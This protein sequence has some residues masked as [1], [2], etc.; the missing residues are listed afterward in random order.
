M[1]SA[2]L[3]AL[4]NAR[5]QSEAVV[6][7]TDLE[8]GEQDLL[9]P[10]PARGAA[11]EEA[12]DPAIAEAARQAVLTDRSRVFETDSGRVFLHVFN[13]SVHVI[14][15]GAVHIAQPL[16]AMA[17]RAGYRVTVV[18]PRAAFATAE[19]FP[20]IPLLHAWP[21]EGLS[22]LGFDRRTALVTVT[23][24]PKLD[25]PALRAALASPAF[26]VGALGSRRNHAVRLE[27]LRAAGFGD[28]DF[29][30]IHAPI[31]LDI[32]AR[33]PGE[34]A[35]AILAEIVRELRAESG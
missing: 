10:F 28:D 24:D 31:G 16:S 19:R 29:A 33:T 11:P 6:L 13:P 35:V 9:R 22:Q 32:G 12:P 7:V 23:H 14:I 1:R 15:V 26:Y 4:L 34:I 8:T 30:R 2:T 27:R 18:D 5:A 20:G 25:D 21:E 3:D 17:V